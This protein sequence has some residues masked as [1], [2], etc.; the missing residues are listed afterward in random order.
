MKAIHTAEAAGGF[1]VSRVFE[2]SGYLLLVT[3][4]LLSSAVK[5]AQRGGGLS[6]YSQYS[7]NSSC[8]PSPISLL[9]E[10][11]RGAP[12]NT[13]TDCL[14]WGASS[15]ATTTPDGLQAPHCNHKATSSVVD[16]ECSRW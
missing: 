1:G 7:P 4:R 16:D 6:L 9:Q 13:V 12:P 11:P 10:V 14:D 8:R 15:E 5:L 3:A 2:C